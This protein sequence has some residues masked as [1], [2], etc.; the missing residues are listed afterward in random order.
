MWLKLPLNISGWQKKEAQ[1]R[2]FIHNKDQMHFPKIDEIYGSD[3]IIIKMEEQIK[4]MQKGQKQ[5]NNNN[6][7]TQEN[8]HFE[9]NFKLRRTR[10]KMLD[11]EKKRC[12]NTDRPADTTECIRRFFES[13]VNCSMGLDGGKPTIKR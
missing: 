5:E 7:D 8:I 12:D 13:K 4:L 10:W 3:F 11:T 1:F 2:I 9:Q 6:N